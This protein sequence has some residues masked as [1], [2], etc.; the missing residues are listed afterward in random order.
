[1]ANV[2]IFL[3]VMG[4]ALILML[5]VTTEAEKTGIS[6]FKLT[7]FGVLVLIPIWTMMFI[8]Y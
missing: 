6:T 3:F 1:M 7:I 2:L 8:G 5:L 4:M